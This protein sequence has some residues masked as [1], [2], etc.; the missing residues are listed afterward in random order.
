MNAA[1]WETWGGV[2]TQ[3]GKT[4]HKKQIFFSKTT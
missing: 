2:F 4:Y 1:P 3:I